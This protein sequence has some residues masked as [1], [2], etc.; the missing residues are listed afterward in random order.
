LI[1]Q[2]YDAQESLEHAVDMVR[3]E[4]PEKLAEIAD[5]IWANSV[6]L[7]GEDDPFFGRR[8]NPPIPR[9]VTHERVPTRLAAEADL[10]AA[11]AELFPAARRYL[12]GGRLR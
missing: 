11:H 7:A 3:L 8:G 2:I 5:R 10:R 1:E 4:G 12:N 6:I 9:Y